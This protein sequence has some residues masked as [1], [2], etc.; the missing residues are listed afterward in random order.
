M[1]G[2]D[3]F[4]SFWM[5]SLCFS[6]L[7]SIQ[8]TGRPVTTDSSPIPPFSP[9]FDVMDEYPA[10]S[11]RPTPPPPPPTPTPQIKQNPSAKGRVYLS[12]SGTGLRTNED[13]GDKTEW[14]DD[15]LLTHRPGTT[16][17]GIDNEENPEG[18]RLVESLTRQEREARLKLKVKEI[19]EMDRVRQNQDRLAEQEDNVQREK[20]RKEREAA[21]E[22][23]KEKVKPQ[24]NEDWGYKKVEVLPGAPKS[25]ME[26]RSR[27]NTNI[28]QPFP[29]IHI[30]DWARAVSCHYASCPV[31]FTYVPAGGIR[32]T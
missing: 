29:R 1:S 3:L 11:S 14:G 17:F 27:I 19:E 23:A 28:R 16:M 7:N 22:Q 9:L 20:R 5:V 13:E 4:F 8:I 31:E 2:D 32:P 15:E 6:P 10:P 18:P 30:K 24:P 26:R 21:A 25:E 12:N